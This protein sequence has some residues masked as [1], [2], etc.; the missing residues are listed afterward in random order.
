LINTDIE[1]VNKDMLYNYLRNEILKRA[2]DKSNPNP[3]LALGY[4]LSFT[5]VDKNKK[6]IF[7]INIKPSDCSAQNQ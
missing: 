1:N 4:S 7:D 2:C 6:P 5:Y 3:T